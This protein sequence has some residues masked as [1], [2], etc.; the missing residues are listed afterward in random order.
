MDIFNKKALA[1]KEAEIKQLSKELSDKKE[2]NEI[3][4]KKVKKLEIELFQRETPRKY[5][6]YQTIQNFFILDAELQEKAYYPSSV[7]NDLKGEKR[8]WQIILNLLFNVR[9]KLEWKYTYLHSIT[10]EVH[11]IWESELI[12]F[13]IQHQ[14][15]EQKAA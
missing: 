2:V 8:G 1:K 12:N 15:Q 11:K 13:E 5:H 9:N 6:N 4:K 7:Y 14:C 3:L 10:K